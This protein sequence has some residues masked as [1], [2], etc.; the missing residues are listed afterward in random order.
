MSLCLNY[1]SSIKLLSI[2]VLDSPA[3]LRQET[4]YYTGD[5]NI[6]VKFTIF[7][8]NLFV[9][10]FLFLSSFHWMMIGLIISLFDVTNNFHK[11]CNNYVLYKQQREK[12]Y[13]STYLSLLNISSYSDW[14]LFWDAKLLRTWE[15]MILFK[16]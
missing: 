10:S 7:I 14:N 16:L 2:I 6:Q 9:L 11:H 13:Y 5:Y 3:R 4:E 12:Y 15:I 8:K 1:D